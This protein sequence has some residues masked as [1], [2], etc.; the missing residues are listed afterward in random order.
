MKLS[1]LVPLLALAA[2]LA[3]QTPL[4]QR[5]EFHEEE[6]DDPPAAVTAAMDPLARSPRALAIQGGVVSIQVNVD[7]AQQNII[8]DAANEPSIAVDPTN[9]NVMVIGWRQFDNISSNFREGGYGYTS[10]G[11][12]TWT[13]GEHTSGLFRSDPVLDVDAVGNIYYMSLQGNFLCDLFTSTTGGSSWQAPVS[14]FGGDK[15]WIAVDRSGGIGDGNVYNIWQ[16]NF[17]CCGNSTLTRSVDSGGSFQNPVFV[18]EKP[19]FGAMTV[20]GDGTL[21]AAGIQ[22]DPFVTTGTFVISKSTNAKNPGLSPSFQGQTVNMGGSMELSVGPNPAGLLGQAWV[23]VDSSG[24]ARD[25]WVYML[26]SV[27][28]PGPDPLDVHLVRSTNGGQ[29]WSSPIRVNDDGVG[30]WQ[31][32]GS[33]SVAPDGRLDVVWNDTRASGQDNISELYYSFSYD[34][35][36]T[37]SANTAISP[38]FDSFLGWPNQN[39]L[40]DYYELVSDATGADLAWAATFNGEQDVYY[41]RISP[42]CEPT[43]YCTAKV[44]SQGCAPAIGSSGAP[45]ASSP[46]AFLIT[47]TNILNNKNG[48]LFRGYA[49]RDATPFLGGTLCVL[50]P[51]A[52]GI[53]QN[54]GGNPPPDDCSGQLE[55]DFNALIQGGTDPFLV[56][57]QT[58]NAQYWTRDPAQLDGTGAGLSNAL[59]FCVCP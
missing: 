43:V 57:G 35:G 6:P 20:G 38:Q 29:N 16:A 58:V 46:N 23:A 11:G 12:Q 7:G 28:P 42:G 21:W 47:A 10:D 26:C 22:G 49:G 15:E 51:L 36:D 59:E 13:V 53:V 18:D 4:V 1:L 54:A 55:V 14:A 37:W 19:T 52:R 25:G 27:N 41:T 30:E 3:A 33:L 2:P 34:G 31:W 24:G 40:G 32:F 17:G 48:L 5:A 44:N 8:G 9:P 50:P 39:K 56:P 45:S